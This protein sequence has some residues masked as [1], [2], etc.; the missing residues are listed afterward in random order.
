VARQYRGKCCRAASPL[1]RIGGPHLTTLMPPSGGDNRVQHK[2]GL[3]AACIWHPHGSALRKAH[4]AMLFR[5]PPTAHGS[6]AFFGRCKRN[7]PTSFAAR[8]TIIRRAD[9]G[10]GGIYYRAFV[11]PFASAEKATKLCSGLKAAGG[12]CIIQKN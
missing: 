11:G 1:L 10:A 7:T 3:P 4:L 12:G 6:G 9:L 2:S 5:L 8:Q